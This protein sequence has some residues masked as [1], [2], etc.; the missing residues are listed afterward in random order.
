MNLN[1][2]FFPSTVDF[3][4]CI[5]QYS[6]LTSHPFQKDVETSWLLGSAK[7]TDNVGMVQFGHQGDLLNQP[8]LFLFLLRRSVPNV[9]HL[10]NQIYFIKYIYIHTIYEAVITLKTLIYTFVIVPM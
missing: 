7:A 5:P 6:C 2:K 3:P 10:S 1:T 9:G 4:K 8:L